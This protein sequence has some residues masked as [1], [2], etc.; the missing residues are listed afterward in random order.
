MRRFFTGLL[1]AVV[2]GGAV[3][4]L[5]ASNHDQ[6][7]VAFEYSDCGVKLLRQMIKEDR[8]IDTDET[9]F[10][11]LQEMREYEKGHDHKFKS[12]VLMSDMN[13][14][15][16]DFTDINNLPNL[17]S[18]NCKKLGGIGITFGNALIFLV[19]L[20]GAGVGYFLLRKNQAKK[21]ESS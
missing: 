8:W 7:I 1:L 16:G 17:L 15:G 20:V 21:S 6:G 5:V 18:K 9:E 14:I 11:S 2:I 10:S 19:V 13:A 12:Y 4:L 3:S